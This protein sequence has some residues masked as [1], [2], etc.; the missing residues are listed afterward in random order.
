[1]STITNIYRR[2]VGLP[3]LA[4]ALTA[5][6]LA[7]DPQ[8]AV[9]MAVPAQFK[10]AALTPEEAGAPAALPASGSPWWTV[11]NDPVLDRLEEQAVAS[12]QDLQGAVAR[13]TEARAAASLVASDLYPKV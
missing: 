13:V 7:A 11:F 9:N 6:A 1:M 10:S 4:A 8:P 3:A 12:N 5:S 2:L